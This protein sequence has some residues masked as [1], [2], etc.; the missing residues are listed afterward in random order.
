MRAKIEAV[1][2]GRDLRAADRGTRVASRDQAIVTALGVIVAPRPAT[3]SSSGSAYRPSAASSAAA[4][5]RRA[6]RRLRRPSPPFRGR[7]AAGRGRRHL[8]ALFPAAIGLGI[9]LAARWMSPRK[10]SSSRLSFVPFW[11][12]IGQPRTGGRHAVFK[13]SHCG[14]Q[15]ADRFGRSRAGLSDPR[16]QHGD[17]VSA[18]RKH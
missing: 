11:L 18:G 8:F 9:R 2:G 6:S 12:P 7:S 10:Q 4:R 17:P 16:R 5:P 14:G 13:T 1:L 15:R 3:R